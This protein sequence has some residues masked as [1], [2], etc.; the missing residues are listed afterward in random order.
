MIERE[1]EPAWKPAGTAPECVLVMT[2]IDDERGVRNEQ[3]MER[4]G[5]LWWIHADGKR[6]MYV[7]YEPT[8][9]RALTAA[10]RLVFTR[11]ER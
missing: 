2:K 1:I 6:H 11:D 3:P 10:D 7:Y 9:W 4:Q 8:H 5:R